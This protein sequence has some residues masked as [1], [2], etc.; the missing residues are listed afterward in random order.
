MKRPN[1]PRNASRV[2]FIVLAL[3]GIILTV[4]AGF[5]W[6]NSLAGTAVGWS[7]YDL[8]VEF[9][10]SIALTVLTLIYWSAMAGRIPP[11]LRWTT[12]ATVAIEM[13]LVALVMIV[14]GGALRTPFFFVPVL[15]MA[16]AVAIPFAARLVTPSRSG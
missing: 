7:V 14:F 6:W 1:S 12:L 4:Q 11:W 8:D 13:L 3:V 15:M 5:S 9:A 16:L 10:T 2:S